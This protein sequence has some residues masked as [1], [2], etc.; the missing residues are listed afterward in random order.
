MATTEVDVYRSVRKENFPEGVIVN[1]HA[2]TGVLYP[3]FESTTFQTVVR[4]V[5]E[6]RT[7]GADVTPYLHNNQPVIDPG[8][9]TSLFDK[10]N[11]FGTKYWWNFKIPAGTI[12]PDSL[13]VRFTGHNDT[14]GADHYQIEALAKRMTVVAYKGALDNL[15]RNAIV[16]SCETADS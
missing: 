9:G 1:G 13:K 5:V 2:V 4:G 10:A 3:T 8:A 16:R 11:V 15:A 12:V 7:R 14:Y 6:T